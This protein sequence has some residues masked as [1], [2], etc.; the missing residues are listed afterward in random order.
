MGSH[1]AQVRSKGEGALKGR[2]RSSFEG[3][4]GCPEEDFHSRHTKKSSK[5]KNKTHTHTHTIKH[6]GGG[7]LRRGASEGGVSEGNVLNDTCHRESY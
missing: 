2:L 7:G 6:K 1:T 4:E 5:K 3:G